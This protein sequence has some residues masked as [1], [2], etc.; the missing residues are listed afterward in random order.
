MRD[1]CV[2]QASLPVDVKN[3]T[4]ANM[5]TGWK[6]EQQRSLLREVKY[7]QIEPIK[8]QQKEVLVP[9]VRTFTCK[10]NSHDVRS[11]SERTVHTSV[12][13]TYKVLELRG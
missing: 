8:R 3:Q 5:P 6:K 1:P 7:F 13:H 10:T 9:L 11:H 12:S 4:H 2:L